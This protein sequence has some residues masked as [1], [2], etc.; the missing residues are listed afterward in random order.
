MKFDEN[1]EETKICPQSRSDRDSYVKIIMPNI[2]EKKQPNFKKY[3]SKIINHFNLPY[4]FEVHNND[5][6]LQKCTTCN[7]HNNMVKYK[8]PEHH[9]LLV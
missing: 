4:D 3:S 9:A 8:H 2:P 5:Y 1:Y 7:L 6:S